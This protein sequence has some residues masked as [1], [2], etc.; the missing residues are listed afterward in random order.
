MSPDPCWCPGSLVLGLL[1]V[2]FLVVVVD[3]GAG[4]GGVGLVRERQV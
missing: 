2:A 4:L 3:C 1:G